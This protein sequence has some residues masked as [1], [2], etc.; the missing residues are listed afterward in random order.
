MVTLSIVLTVGGW[1]T[2]VLN[3]DT[4]LVLIIAVH[5]ADDGGLFG[6]DSGIVHG[7]DCKDAL[8]T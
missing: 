4:I 1:H 3:S 7:A 5:G 6:A 2:L 8:I